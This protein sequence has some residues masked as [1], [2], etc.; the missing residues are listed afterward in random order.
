LAS[1]SAASKGRLVALE[2]AAGPE[3]VPSGK[4]LL[5][6]LLR[7][8]DEGGVSSFDASG[9]FFEL[10]K[11]DKEIPQPSPRTLVLLYAADLMFRLRW[12]IRPALEEGMLVVAAPY[13]DTGIAFGKAAGLPKRWLV[14]LFSF[15]PRAEQVYRLKEKREI[16]GWKF[17]RSQGYLEFC[18]K[19]L[20]A[21]SP[22]WHPEE[23]RERLLGYLDALER[24]G[25][26]QTAT[27]K[28]LGR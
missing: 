16:S 18:C 9:I 5:D 19:T 11:G 6:Q 21:S 25:G 14:E 10:R 2:G 13:V 24:R 7:G 28:I 4:R 20:I 3:L 12:E 17:K 26:C 15:A 1:N 22:A 27:E 23:L 8:R